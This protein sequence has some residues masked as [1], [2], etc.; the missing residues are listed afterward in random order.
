MAGKLIMVTGG[1]RSGKSEFAEKYVLH[2][3]PKCDYIATAEILDEEM[4]ERVRE[5]L[6]AD[7]GVGVTGLA[8]PDGDGVHE[9]GTVFV[10]M[11]TAE[12][13]YVRELHLGV[14]RT[15]S[16]VRQMSG[17]YAFDMIRRYLTGIKVM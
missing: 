9:V 10:S 3:S 15:R 14:Q 8:G 13:T 5:K 4:A 7:I 16:F 1:A 17:N 11:A 6:G 2:Y 12:K